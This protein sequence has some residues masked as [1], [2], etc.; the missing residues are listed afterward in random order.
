MHSDSWESVDRLLQAFGE[1]GAGRYMKK[2]ASNSDNSTAANDA[3]RD[4]MRK[5]LRAQWQ[6]KITA[7]R[8]QVRISA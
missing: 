1:G 4:T 8:S 7:A 2:A 3:E 5:K 6:Q